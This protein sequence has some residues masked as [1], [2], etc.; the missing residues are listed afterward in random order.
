MPQ[1]TWAERWHYA[2]RNVQPAL[3]LFKANRRH[4]AQLLEV[5]PAAWDRAVTISARGHDDERASVAEIVELQ[6]RHALGHIT[7]IEAILSMEVQAP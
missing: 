4:L 2:D 1:T 6:A 7:E 3:G 5:V